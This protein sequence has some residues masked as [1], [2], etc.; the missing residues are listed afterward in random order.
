MRRRLQIDLRHIG[1][2]GQQPKQKPRKPS[3]VMG[4][5]VHRFRGQSIFRGG[6]CRSVVG[7]TGCP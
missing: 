2:S 6:V 4:I 3:Q 1:P 5:V 7:G